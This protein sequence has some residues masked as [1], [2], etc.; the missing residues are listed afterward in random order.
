[1]VFQSQFTS[2]IILYLSGAHFVFCSESSVS[3]GNGASFCDAKAIRK[4][5]LLL[6]PPKHL[7]K[8]LIRDQRE[9]DLLECDRR[10]ATVTR[11]PAFDYPQHHEGKIRKHRA[12]RQRNT[13]SGIENEGEARTTS[14]SSYS[15]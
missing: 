2:N 4:A 3:L 11:T 5:F 8:L 14:A 6:S 1:M 13:R 15:S 10:W 12:L 7:H 9:Y